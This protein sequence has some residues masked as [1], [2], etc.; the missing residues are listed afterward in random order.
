M[1]KWGHF[2]DTQQAAWGCNSYCAVCCTKS[3]GLKVEK[4]VFGNEKIKN[5]IFTEHH[6][7]CRWWVP[8][9]RG[10]RDQRLAEPLAVET[11]H[12]AKEVKD[13]VFPSPL[14]LSPPTPR[15]FFSFF[16]WNPTP[17]LFTLGFE[18]DCELYLLIPIVAVAY[19]YFAMRMFFFSPSASS[20]PPSLPLPGVRGNR[21]SREAAR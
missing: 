13:K 12:P 14:P 19:A 2:T 7:R 1:T 10:E 11:T 9:K 16:F 20:C 3:C 5:R 8:M 18:V 6:C 15:F 4:R 17:A 21:P